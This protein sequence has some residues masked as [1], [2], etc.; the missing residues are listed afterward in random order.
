MHRGLNF[1]PIQRTSFKQENGSKSMC[2][3]NE[4]TEWSQLYGSAMLV[5]SPSPPL[6]KGPETPKY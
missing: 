3:W 2:E 1:E 5:P 4:Q 6:Q